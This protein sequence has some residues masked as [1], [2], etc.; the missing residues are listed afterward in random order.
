MKYRPLSLIHLLLLVLAL[1]LA[2]FLA[3][4]EHKKTFAPDQKIVFVVDINRSM[5][6]EDVFLDNKSISRLQAAKYIIHQSIESQSSYSYGLIVFN[7]GVDYIVPPSFDTWT[8]LLYLSG[9]TTNLLPDW[10]KDFAQ[11]SWVLTTTPSTSYLIISDFDSVQQDDIKLP[12]TVSLLGLGS[13]KG[14]IVRY[15]NGV[16]YYDRGKSVVS[17]RNDN[18]A[19]SFRLPYVSFTDVTHVSL[20]DILSSSFALPPNQR[21]FLFILLGV[22]V[23]LVIFL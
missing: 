15:A 13:I 17:V 18:M 20:Q 16:R 7:A 6:T 21:V 22:L 19:K 3:F 5:N 14:D 9:I 10:I 8:F 12:K 4:G 2:G 23:I 11:L 1:F